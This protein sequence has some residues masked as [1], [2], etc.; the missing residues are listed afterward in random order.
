MKKTQE[1]TRKTK[2]IR[3]RVGELLRVV[4]DS[5]P[6][7]AEGAA[8]AAMPADKQLPEEESQNEENDGA[9]NEDEEDEEEDYEPQYYFDPADVQTAVDE[10][11]SQIIREGLI[12]EV[13]D[14]ME[15]PELT[16]IFAVL[17][18]ANSEIKEQIE[19]FE[20]L[21]SGY[22]DRAHVDELKE[23]YSILESVIEKISAK[24]PKT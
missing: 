11:I 22:E 16:D 17:F 5:F 3:R 23:A 24:T 9:K 20:E 19:Y 2:A 13:S 12:E 8:N 14:P 4:L 21:I 15:P 18:G 7:E 1:K 10:A 6:A